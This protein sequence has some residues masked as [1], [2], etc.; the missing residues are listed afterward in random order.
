MV[1]N[2]SECLGVS[3]NGF[4]HIGMSLGIREWFLTSRNVF[5]Y[6]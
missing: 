2:I 1:L 4:E 5:G 3:V 6:F